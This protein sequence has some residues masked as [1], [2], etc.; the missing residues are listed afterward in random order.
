MVYLQRAA[1]STTSELSI[2][3]DHFFVVV[4]PDFWGLK[5][6]KKNCGTDRNFLGS[7]P[8][9]ARAM[10]TIPKSIAWVLSPGKLLFS[11]FLTV[12]TSGPHEQKETLALLLPALGFESPPS[13]PI[14]SM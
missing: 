11:T 4:I 1:I 2:V 5:S 3:L 9:H 7:V 14:M 6:S 10:P 8:G 13:F 12:G